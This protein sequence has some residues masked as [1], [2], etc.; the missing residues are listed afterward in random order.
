MRTVQ[1]DSCLNSEQIETL[2]ISVGGQEGRLGGGG[3]FKPE[4]QSL[5]VT[6]MIYFWGGVPRGVVPL[7]SLQSTL[8]SQRVNTERKEH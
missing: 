8:R 3:H 5:H 6:V 2:F 7:C 1:A 4:A